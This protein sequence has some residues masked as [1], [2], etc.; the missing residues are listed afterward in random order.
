MTIGGKYDKCK[1]NT[2]VALY[3]F[4]DKDICCYWCRPSL[5]L[6]PVSL[7]NQLFPSYRLPGSILIPQMRNI[8]KP[9][10]LDY[11][12]TIYQII[13]WRMKLQRMTR[14]NHEASHFARF[15]Y[16][17]YGVVADTCHIPLNPAKLCSAVRT[18]GPW[19]LSSR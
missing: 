8:R 10:A 3:Q 16:H 6:Q 11:M 4:V 18:R 15:R 12:T 2:N 14:R 17:G 5:E 1:H 19:A 9:N 7:C 13:R